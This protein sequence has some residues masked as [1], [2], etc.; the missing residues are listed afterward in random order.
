MPIEEIKPLDWKR[1][2]QSITQSLK[3]ARV[4]VQVVNK[5]GA[6]EEVISDLPLHSFRFDSSDACRDQI[7]ISAG[8]SPTRSF[9]VTDPLKIKLRHT[10]AGE[11]NPLEIQSEEGIVFVRF[12]P[13]LRRAYTDFLAA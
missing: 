9:T 5:R 2:C 4:T 8:E 12:D 7:V 13:S 11:F 6:I 10:D 1:F 3:E